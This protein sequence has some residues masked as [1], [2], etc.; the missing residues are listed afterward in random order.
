[1]LHPLPR[2]VQDAIAGMPQPPEPQRRATARTDQGITSQGRLHPVAI[3]LP[4]AWRSQLGEDLLHR[5]VQGGDHL[6]PHLG[7]DTGGLQAI[8]PDALEPLRIC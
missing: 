4:F 6:L 3:A 5:S 8:I 7:Q 1:M 2:I